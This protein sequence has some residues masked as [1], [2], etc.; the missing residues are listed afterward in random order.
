MQ[1]EFS[2]PK[3]ELKS[4]LRLYHFITIKAECMLYVSKCFIQ[5]NSIKV[6]S[7]LL[8]KNF[9]IIVRNMRYIQKIFGRKGLL[10]VDA[11]KVYV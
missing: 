3:L 5:I 8:L 6:Q 4:L 7:E 11:I 1:D 10:Y 2:D 9:E